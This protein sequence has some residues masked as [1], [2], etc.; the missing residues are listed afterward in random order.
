MGRERLDHK[1]GRKEEEVERE[2]IDIGHGRLRGIQR[3]SNQWSVGQVSGLLYSPGRA[4][5]FL[6]HSVDPAL[7]LA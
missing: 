5:V 3:K 1:K 7:S 2:P 4:D 6:L